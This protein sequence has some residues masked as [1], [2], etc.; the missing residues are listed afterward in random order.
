MGRKITTS[1]GEFF[2]HVTYGCGSVLVWRHC[3]TFT[4]VFLDDIKFAHDGQEWVMQKGVYSKW[5]CMDQHIT[6]TQTDPPGG[7]TGLGAE[8]DIYD[9]IVETCADGGR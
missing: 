9:C 8:S 1:Q 7:S 5:L 3:D 6:S 2:V 4:S